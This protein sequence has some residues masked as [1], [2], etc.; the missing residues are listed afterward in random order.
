MRRGAS[1]FF[2][3]L[4][5]SSPHLLIA[6]AIASPQDDYKKTQKEIADTKAEQEDLADQAQRVDA[7]LKELQE[8][9]VESADSVQHG[10]ADL[11]GAEDK[12]RIVS[13]QLADKKKSLE[14]HRHELQALTQAALRLSQVPPEAMVMMPGDIGQTVQASRALKMASDSIREETESLGQQLTELEHIKRKVQREQK[15]AGRKRNT[16]AV[17]RRDLE[18]K[19]AERQRLREKLGEEQEEA[20]SRLDLLAKKAETLQ[21]L[22]ASLE[23][24]E[25]EDDLKEDERA[26]QRRGEHVFAGRIRSFAAARG[27]IRT[28]AAGR[29]VQNFGSGSGAMDKGIVILTHAGAQVT[30]P[31]DGEV[32]FTGPFLGY[33]KLVILRHGDD[34]HTLLAGLEKIDASAG[35]FL[36]EGEPIG[37]MGNDDAGNRLY[38]ELRRHNQPIDPRPWISG[39]NK[40]TR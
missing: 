7:E 11:S 24:E 33:G 13:E 8:S 30:A 23:K 21:G 15:E 19:L 32:V 22:M 36:L 27:H 9:L 5:L 38:V 2:I 28:P 34:F 18:E 20:K 26:P 35:Q 6:P 17:R 40:M 29:V 4:I 10:E 1:I 37:A 14:K 39:L 12:L 3:L 31:Y 16:L 25:E